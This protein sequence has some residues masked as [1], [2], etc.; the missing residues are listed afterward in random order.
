M[1]TQQQNVSNA[2]RSIS[3]TQQFKT[4][5]SLAQQLSREH[6]TQEQ[7]NNRS[8]ANRQESASLLA[9][10]LNDT[11]KQQ[12][13]TEVTVE[14]TEA[15]L[16]DM[17]SLMETAVIKKPTEAQE[18]EFNNTLDKVLENKVMQES[19][20]Q[21]DASIQALDSVPSIKQFKNL[22]EGQL[23]TGLEQVSNANR[24]MMEVFKNPASTPEQQSE[25]IKKFAEALKDAGYPPQVIEDMQKVIDDN[26]NVAKQV[27]KIVK[28]LENVKTGEPWYKPS[29]SKFFTFFVILAAVL[30]PFMFL[31]WY[32]NQHA[33]CSIFRASNATVERLE[34]G[35]SPKFGE[36]KS[37]YSE[38][39]DNRRFCSCG[40]SRVVQ[41]GE[42]V[43]CM[44]IQLDTNISGDVK[45][46]GEISEIAK[47][48]YC[49]NTAYQ[50][51]GGQTNEG[52]CKALGDPSCA[53]AVGGNKVYCNN[54]SKNG[55]YYSYRETNIWE[56]FK[57]VIPYISG[58]LDTGLNALLKW[59]LIIG[60]VILGG[61][62]VFFIAKRLV[63]SAPNKKS[64]SSESS[65]NIN[66]SL[67]P[68]P[69]NTSLS[70][71]SMNTT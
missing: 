54:N 68:P 6:I 31:L 43:D 41:N 17:T 57:D 66:I 14:Q 32:E 20:A 67:S 3:N 38:S 44:N 65:E 60:A 16:N 50:Y 35:D 33:G 4:Q 53:G 49:I 45:C 9:K 48:P 25:A 61:S 51:K 13:R 21:M 2:L 10:T 40:G 29:G 18:A 11:A 34:C 24:E 37:W 70:P 62:L 23:P 5:M 7:Y 8:E 71:S 55:W 39:S 59:V 19:M 1:P 30:G 12:G 22:I 56:F 27:E 26:P 58:L 42:V 64:K 28:E 69:M 47:A 63:F 36:Q 46:D 15:L 52:V